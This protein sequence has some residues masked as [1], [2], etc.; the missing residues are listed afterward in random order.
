MQICYPLPFAYN[1]KNINIIVSCFIKWPKKWHFTIML[2]HQAVYIY[3]LSIIH[4][5][6]IH[7]QGSLIK[8]AKWVILDIQILPKKWIQS[9]VMCINFCAHVNKFSSLRNNLYLL[10]HVN[11][12]FYLLLSMETRKIL[13]FSNYSVWLL[14]GEG[15]ILFVLMDNKG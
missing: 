15:S 7:F 4:D 1:T 14:E 13:P 11:Y 2:L 8:L 6:L 9:P 10:K 3:L 5:F 12:S